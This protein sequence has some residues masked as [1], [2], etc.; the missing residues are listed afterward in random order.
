MR[1]HELENWALSVLERVAAGHPIEDSR[2][3]LKAEW[4]APAKVARQIAGHAN[5]ARGDPILWL[6]GVDQ[7]NGVTG[8]SI[9]EL[10]NWHAAVKTQFDG[11]A[12]TLVDLNVPWDKVTV[13]A[14]YFETDRAPFVVKNPA[15]GQPGGGPVALEV[16]WRENTSTRSASRAELLR[17]L[18]PLQRLPSMEVLWGSLHA[19]SPGPLQKPARLKWTLRLGLYVAPRG[20]GRVVIPSH[21]CKGTFQIEGCLRETPL[22]AIVFLGLNRSPLAQATDTDAV[23]SGPGSVYLGADAK[24]PRLKGAYRKPAYLILDLP[25]MDAEGSVSLSVTLN[26]TGDKKAGA[27]SWSLNTVGDSTEE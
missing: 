3:E 12:P 23:F 25:V 15:H 13:V 11:L 14:L 8:A 6:V 10:A 20:N 2:V 5:A 21:K 4:V 24:T 27:Y 1:K 19:D 18:S 16:P 22:Q 17:L 26:Y 7:K 9:M